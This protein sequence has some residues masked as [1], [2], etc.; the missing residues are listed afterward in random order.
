VKLY[1]NRSRLQAIANANCLV[2]IPEGKD[3]LNPGEMIPA[4]MLVPCLAGK[5]AGI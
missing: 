5:E 4:Q 2:C 1:K 3:S